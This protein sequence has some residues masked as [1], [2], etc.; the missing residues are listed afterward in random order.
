MAFWNEF[1]F[2]FIRI[3][4]DPLGSPWNFPPKKHHSI[5]LLDFDFLEPRKGSKQEI[6]CRTQGLTEQ[7]H[8]LVF[9][10]QLVATQFARHYG[11]RSFL[12]HCIMAKHHRSLHCQ[13][14][15]CTIKGKSIDYYHQKYGLF[16]MHCKAH[17]PSSLHK[18]LQNPWGE[19]TGP[20]SYGVLDST[21]YGSQSKF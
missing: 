20:G 4:V 10:H 16:R 19:G 8:W 6:P 1:V 11:K 18:A 13:L 12:A 7:G 9:N 15:Q 17:Q 14:P 3:S 5:Q 21:S 2:V